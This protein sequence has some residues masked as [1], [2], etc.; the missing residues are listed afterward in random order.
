MYGYGVWPDDIGK[1]KKAADA[2]TIRAPIEKDLI[3]T[4]ALRQAAATGDAVTV[5]VVPVAGHPPQDAGDAM[6]LEGVSIEIHPT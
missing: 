3:A 4:D 2:D 6:K 5:T 1:E